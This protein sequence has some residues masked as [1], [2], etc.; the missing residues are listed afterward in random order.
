MNVEPPEH[1]TPPRPVLSVTDAF[2]LLAW[3]REHRPTNCM[4]AFLAI[5]TGMRTGEIA[6]LQWRDIDLD[7]GVIQLERTR[8]RPKGGQDFLGPPKTFG[9]RRRIVVTREVVDELRRWKQSQQEF[10]R[11]SWTP[12]SFVVRLPNS[13]PPSPA[14]LTT[15]SKT[16]EK[17]LGC[18]R[19]PFMD[20]DIPM[21]RGC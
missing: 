2:R 1:K 9:S 19:F 6:G 21:R 13:A 16:Q 5:H 8:Y 10:E 12:E 20:W 14:S 11:E 7:T 18:R 15:R 17:S 3:L 4:A